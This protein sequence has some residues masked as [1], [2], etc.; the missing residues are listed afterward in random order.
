MSYEYLKDAFH[1]NFSRIYKEKWK[2]KGK[3]QEEF[4]FA[5]SPEGKCNTNSVSNWLTGK[6]YPQKYIDAI[7]EVLEVNKDDFFKED[8]HKRILHDTA[9]A[10]E[11]TELLSSIAEKIGLDESFANYLL[12]HYGERII[13]A[14]NCPCM[15]WINNRELFEDKDFLKGYKT[16]LAFPN[17]ADVGS[18][19]QGSKNP[20]GSVRQISS[21]VLFAMNKIQNGIQIS[22][23]S[24]CLFKM[25]QDHDYAFIKL[26]FNKYRSEGKKDKQKYIDICINGMIQLSKAKI[27]EMFEDLEGEENGTD[28]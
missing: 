22:G 27:I 28:S 8:S 26:A 17:I 20:D 11:Y 19:Y 7:A 23:L 2:S 15:D 4:A 6:Q 1:E 14:S 10:N 16:Y 9:F 21:S 13:R 18:V 3:T 24:H 25:E 5:I 12:R